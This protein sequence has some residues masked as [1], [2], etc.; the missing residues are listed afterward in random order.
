MPIIREEDR[1]IVDSE[2]SRLAHDFRNLG[3][4]PQRTFL[5]LLGAAV[6]SLRVD[7]L[8]FLA[9][10]I[11]STA[12]LHIWLNNGS[13]GASCCQADKSADVRRNQMTHAGCP[14]V[15]RFGQALTCLQCV[16]NCCMYGNTKTQSI[17]LEF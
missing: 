1:D 14:H 17:F 2:N 5:G 7:S 11:L 10:A 16:D 13:I 4:I 6:A 12:L 3:R 8:I 15:F 9:S